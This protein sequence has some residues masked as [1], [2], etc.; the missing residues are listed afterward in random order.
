MGSGTPSR[1]AAGLVR[2]ILGR[3]AGLGFVA[4]VAFLAGALVLL[5]FTVES[6]RSRGGPALSARTAVRIALALGLLALVLRGGRGIN[7]AA[8]LVLGGILVAG[9]A[10]L[11]PRRVSEYPAS[12]TRHPT[13]Y[14][15]F[16]GLP[17]AD[18]HN[19]SERAV[20]IFQAGASRTPWPQAC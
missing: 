19:I 5:A 2:P 18:E 16:T 6:A 11:H 15:M 14:L 13:P 9:Q 4:N 17:G 10:W 1:P 8:A 7:L 20:N 12:S 3:L